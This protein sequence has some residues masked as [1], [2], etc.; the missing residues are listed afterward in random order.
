M[1]Y[2]VEHPI[3][4][5]SNS[6]SL[7][8]CQLSPPP[9]TIVWKPLPWPY[10]AG[11]CGTKTKVQ[12][13]LKQHHVIPSAEATEYSVRFGSVRWFGVFSAVRFGSVRWKILTEPPN[14]LFKKWPGIGLFQPSFFNY[15]KKNFMDFSVNFAIWSMFFVWLVLKTLIDALLSI[16]PYGQCFLSG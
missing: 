5:S 7:C 11:P 10:L 3:V 14:F 6:R 12:L 16:L 13:F 4:Q 2:S 15:F 8:T 1:R 9:Y